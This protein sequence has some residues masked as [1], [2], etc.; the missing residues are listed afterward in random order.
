MGVS[1][2]TI[3]TYVKRMRQK[4]GLGNK[5]DLTCKAIELGRLDPDPPG[6]Q[7]TAHRIQPEQAAYHVDMPGGKPMIRRVRPT[8]T[9]AVAKLLVGAFAELEQRF[10]WP[11]G[12][13]QYLRGVADVQ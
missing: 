8:E 13:D 7:S 4:L 6:R 10:Y 9:A 12:W 11:D 5:A 2:T 1:Q 3:D